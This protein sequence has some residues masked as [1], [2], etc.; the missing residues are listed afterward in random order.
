MDNSVFFVVVSL[1]VVML[2]YGSVAISP[3][4]AFAAGKSPR[5][6]CDLTPKS[7]CNCYNGVN[8]LK[9][10]CCSYTSSGNVIACEECDINTVTGDY[11]NCH[12]ITVNKSPT[13]GTANVPQGS[14]VLEQPSTPKKHA[15]A[16]PQDNDGRVAEQP[17]QSSNHSPKQNTK[18]TKGGNNINPAIGK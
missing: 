7:Q 13:T 14:G 9:A 17:L 15:G 2:I 3:Y 1:L 6:V 18:L 12:D 5:D 11:E 4:S 16:V 10:S 8:N